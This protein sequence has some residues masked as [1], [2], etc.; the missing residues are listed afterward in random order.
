[1]QFQRINFFQGVRVE[2]F[3]FDMFSMDMEKY[4]CIL[5]CESCCKWCPGR[6]FLG[7]IW[8]SAIIDLIYRPVQFNFLRQVNF[9][10][11]RSIWA[12]LS[13]AIVMLVA[14]EYGPYF[15]TPIYNN[16]Q[17]LIALPYR[18]HAHTFGASRANKKVF[19]S[20]RFFTRKRVRIKRADDL[21]EF[22]KL[23]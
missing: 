21:C 7:V 10:I 12:D 13:F 11:D 23:K 5:G 15:R 3:H 4:H 17:Y 16:I 19:N 14:G 8:R 2:H 18:R 1:M 22:F 6:F 9:R 20:C